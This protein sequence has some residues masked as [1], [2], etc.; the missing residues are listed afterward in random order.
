LIEALQPFGVAAVA[1]D[2]RLLADHL[3]WVLGHDLIVLVRR[4]YRGPIPALLDA[5]A[6]AGVPVILDMD[7]YLFED[8]VIPHSEYLRSMPPEQ[9]GAILSAYRATFERCR[10]FTGA[11]AFLTERAAA[12][13][14]VACR[15]RNGLNE[16][17]IRLALD[18]RRRRPAA[19]P[20]VV[21]IGFFSGTSTHNADFGLIA[22]TLARLLA[23]LPALRLVVVGSLDL[24]ALPELTRFGHRVEHRPL[25]DWRDLPAEIARVDVNVIPLQVNP[26]NEGKSNLKYYEAATVDVPSVASP[27]RALAESITDGADGFLAAGEHD[28]YAKLRALVVDASLRHRV[29]QAAR[30][31][32]LRE[33]SPSVVGREAAAAYRAILNCHRAR[34]AA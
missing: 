10:Y 14:K 18:L 23:E 17:Q 9:A 34:V 31:R 26:F 2:E 32:A 3:P 25:V 30:R 8:L 33:Y 15:I 28:W 24:G 12:L 27:T 5:A 7:D 13:G 6:A 1:L 29:G 16:V 4:S 19:R 22:P 21:R 11:N 20:G